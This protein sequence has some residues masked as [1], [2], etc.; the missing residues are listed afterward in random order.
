VILAA[1]HPAGRGCNLRFG[2]VA[3]GRQMINPDSMLITL[4][5]NCDHESTARAQRTGKGL[6][7]GLKNHFVAATALTART[8]A[9]PLPR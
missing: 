7:R 8:S 4:G 3:C 6:S 9:Y 1:P 2:S 5:R